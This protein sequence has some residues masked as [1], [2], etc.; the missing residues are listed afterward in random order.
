MTRAFP[1]F[2]GILLVMQEEIVKLNEDGYYINL[3]WM[4]YRVENI[5]SCMYWVSD[6]NDFWNFVI[7][8]SLVDTAFDSKQFGFCTHDMYHMVE[9]FSNRFIMNVCMWY[10]YGNIVFDTSIHNNK[11]M[12][13]NTWGLNN[14]IVKLLDAHF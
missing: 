14:Y 10:R 11:S 1:K 2:N 6:D 5:S 7:T 9:G 8:Y 4:G 3:I 12:W 13:R